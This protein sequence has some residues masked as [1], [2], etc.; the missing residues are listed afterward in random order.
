MNGNAD[1]TMLGESRNP[2]KRTKLAMCNYITDV[3]V[4]K[5]KAILNGFEGIDW[6]FTLQDLPENESEVERLIER[7]SKLKPLEVR[8]H[9]AFNGLDLGDTG[10]DKG[11][12]AIRIFRRACGVVSRLEGRFMTI[13]LGLGRESFGDLS[14]DRSVEALADL[15]SYARGLGVCICLENLASGW[16]SRP[17]LFEKLVRKSNAGVTLDIGHARVSPSVQSQHYTVEDFI[18]PHHERVFNAHIYHEENENGHRP[19][20]KLEDVI[21]RLNLLSSLPCDWWVLELREE[22]PLLSTLKFVRDFLETKSD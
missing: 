16:S 3:E 11:D 6:S 1:F 2:M 18:T 9:C 20:E 7:I 13:H 5:K 4:L 12:R 22:G 19:P 21:D 8:Y 10:V 14:W 15:V 17:E